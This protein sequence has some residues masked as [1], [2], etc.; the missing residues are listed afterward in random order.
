MTFQTNKLSAP[1]ILLILLCSEWD[2]TE[3]SSVPRLQNN[4]LIRIT[5]KKYQGIKYVPDL[6]QN[7]WN[8]KGSV[9]QMVNGWFTD[10]EVTRLYVYSKFVRSIYLSDLWKFPLMLPLT[11]YHFMWRTSPNFSKCKEMRNHCRNGNSPLNCKMKR[12]NIWVRLCVSNHQADD[13]SGFRYQFLTN[14]C[15]S[16]AK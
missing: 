1:L 7:Y 4:Q 2:C 16:V 14:D 3:L 11:T 5:S 9:E 12:T 15:Q 13:S 8:I 6:E 10:S